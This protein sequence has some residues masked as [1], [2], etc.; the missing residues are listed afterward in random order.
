MFLCVGSTE[1]YSHKQC[2]PQGLQ[3]T[4]FPLVEKTLVS[5]FAEEIHSRIL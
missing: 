2:F 3:N 1:T 5:L 4:F